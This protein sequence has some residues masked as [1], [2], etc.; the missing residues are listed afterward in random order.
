MTLTKICSKNILSIK[1][2]P[3]KYQWDAPILNL[4]F[5]AFL[6]RNDLLI[7]SENS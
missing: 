2:S 5:L 3:K 4:L 6:L 1:Q 7:C